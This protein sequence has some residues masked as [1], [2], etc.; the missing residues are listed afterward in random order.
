MG[1]KIEWKDM[2][3]KV[4]P[5]L[6]TALGGPLA[7]IAAQQISNA[8]LGRSDGKDDEI[9]NALTMGGTD[10]LLKLKEADHA[11]LIEMEKIG[12]SREQ[13]G[14][15]DTA[16]AREREIKTGD[17]LTLQ[18]LSGI[19]IGAFLIIVYRVL[20]N[21]M[22]LQDSVIAGALIGYVSAKADTVVGYYFGSS[23]GST[24]KTAALERALTKAAEK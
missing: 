21:G 15:A 9:A 16:S 11:F 2:L 6:A 17:T 18:I 1:R 8:V 5:A 12:L 13:L 14:Y 3:A 4:A 24:E 20:F 19:I 7:G 22:A 23:K 10:A